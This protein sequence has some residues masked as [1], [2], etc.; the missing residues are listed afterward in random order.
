MGGATI[1]T[2]STVSLK[3]IHLACCSYT[4]IEERNLCL[5][6]QGIH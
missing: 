3:H 2:N 6:A 1:K 5:S 4:G